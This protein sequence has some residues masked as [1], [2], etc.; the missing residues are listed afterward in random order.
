MVARGLGPADDTA[1]PPADVV[2]AFAAG[3]LARHEVDA[4]ETHLGTCSRC[5]ATVAHLGRSTQLGAAT[6]PLLPPGTAIDRYQILS[7]VGRGAFGRVYA[8]YDPKLDRRIALKL[9]RGSDTEEAML[10]REARAMA[11][12]SSPHVVA[13]HDAGIVDG[14]LFIAME[15]VDGQT[16]REWLAERTRPADEIIAAFVQAG[17]GLAAAHAANII[18]RDFK[19]ENVLVDTSGRVAVTDFGLAHA[20]DEHARPD[21]LVGTPRYMAPEGLR[22]QPVDARSDVYALCVSLYEALYAT[23]PFPAGSVPELLAAIQRGIKPPRDPRVPR[24]VRDALLAGLAEDPAAR[25]PSMAV[26]L[27]ALERTPRRWIAWAAAGGVAASALA[28]VAVS[29][30]DAASIEV[31]C[32]RDARARVDEIWSAKRRAELRAG[33]ERAASPLAHD[34]AER[35]DLVLD[36]YARAWEHESTRACVIERS[37]EEPGVAATVASRGACLDRLRARWASLVDTLR[38][39]DEVAII[40]AS[41]ASYALPAVDVCGPGRYL[42][43]VSSGV[44]ASAR[45]AIAKAQV[46]ADLGHTDD[47]LAELA[48]PLRLAA[49]RGDRE[50][51]AE[52]KLVQG[53]LERAIAPH[54]AEAP[55]HAAAIAASEVGRLDLEAAA[56]VLLVETLAHSQLRL[57]ESARATEYAQAVVRRLAEPTLVAE[58]AYARGLAE[59]SIGGAERSLPYELATLAIQSVVRGADHPKLAEALNAVAVSLV[60]LEHVAGSIAIQERALRM[61][62]QLQGAEHPEALNA[63]GNLAFALAET[64]RIDEAVAMQEAV[65]AGRA[66]L[67]GDDY[68]LLDETYLRLARLYQWELGR[69]DDA[70]AAARKARAIDEKAFGAD[71]PEGIASLST[72][73]RVLAARSELAEADVAS[74]RA[75]AIAGRALPPTHLIARGALATRADVLARMDRCGEATALVEQLERDSR[76]M[77]SGR[78]ELVFGLHALARCADHTGDPA[79]AE[80]ALLRALAIRERSRG[81]TSPM[82]ADALVELAAFYRAH[83]RAADA[84]ASAERAAAVRTHVPGVLRARAEHEVALSRQR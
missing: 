37:P 27:R 9:I 16:L 42:A 41:S 72:L 36:R 29:R 77:M 25:A 34:V 31:T 1:C 19:P 30:D 82:L 48:G 56:K 61:R 66:R 43:G 40:H 74:E 45:A 23:H 21:A 83:G 79:R 32:A 84:L 22:N 7:V 5:A 58:L 49:E 20:S 78:G 33:I 64:G 68:F 52:A 2:A 69:S 11:G 38:T 46:L 60:E 26:L 55:L 81:P 35:L 17:R 70:L 4:L 15:F 76:P 54:Q 8:A 39:P 65:A 18:H 12:L 13:V 6:G 44:D 59:W 71:G 28:I 51:E 73:A 63:R 14:F 67:L 10:L 53:D 24:H 80:Q 47:G 75:L 3:G 50:L 57:E 62:E